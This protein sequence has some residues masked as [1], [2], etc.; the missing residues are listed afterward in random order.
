[1]RPNGADPPGDPPA[2]VAG[3]VPA[4]DPDDFLS[5]L[6]K[7]LEGPAARLLIVEGIPG[8]GKS[9]LL[10]ALAER[11]GP[12]YLRL[13]YRSTEPLPGPEAQGPDEPTRFSVVLVDAPGVVP[14]EL[15]STLAAIPASRA[16]EQA[17][18]E[19][20]AEGAPEEIVRAI[21]TMAA[22]QR[23]TLFVD[24]W[25][26][27]TLAS[28]GDGHEGRL[29][30]SRLFGSESELVQRF[31]RLPVATVAAILA[32]VPPALR[33]MA[34]GVLHLDQLAWNG[35]PVRLL[36]VE[37]LLA[38]THLEG[39]Q[40]FTLAGGRFYAPPRLA[41]GFVPGPPPLDPDPQPGEPTLWPGSSVY[42]E[43]FG[44]LAPHAMTGLELAVGV[45]NALAE[46]LWLPIVAH[47]V[48]GGGR[49]VVVPPVSTT[50]VELFEKL[51]GKVPAE[52]LRDGL[53]ILSVT[54]AT[55]SSGVPP[56]LRL[57]LAASPRVPSAA[58]PAEAPAAEPMLAGVYEFLAG[59]PKGRPALY[60]ICLDGLR[61]VAAVTGIA[62]EPRTLPLVISLY[63]R[64]PG[65]HGIGIGRSDDPLNSAFQP[66]LALRL[67]LELHDGQALLYEA[68][69]PG[70]CYFLLWQGTGG[71]YRLVRA[72]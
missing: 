17:T 69:P 22:E 9:S 4:S 28:S 8:A 31:S 11:V 19:Y 6:V 27:G 32:P 35:P 55:E 41:R 20:A 13:A 39:R 44:R 42:A 64:L 37:K 7:V 50:P 18:A 15:P 3:P 52:T 16:R 63:A 56:E 57:P 70:A 53:R 33:S 49:A 10:R 12:P 24:A 71:R 1:M 58:G 2:S 30:F 54:D 40:L 72:A 68:D 67:A 36:T 34:D 45:P 65:F 29:A 38:P 51:A 26:R 47:A 60:A 25:D 61:A 43:A 21:A 14:E 48:A 66:S 23:G 5:R 62:L 46:P 59:V